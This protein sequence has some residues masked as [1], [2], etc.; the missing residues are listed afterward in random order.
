VKSPIIPTGVRISAMKFK[1]IDHSRMR[2]TPAP[3]KISIKPHIK[4]QN[5]TPV[6][7]VKTTQ[8]RYHPMITAPLAPRA[9]EPRA[10]ASPGEIICHSC[11]GKMPEDSQRCAI[12][13][14]DLKSPKVRCRRC[15]EINPRGLDKCNR[16]GSGMDE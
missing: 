13:G 7:A 2:K 10:E 1:S 4:S 12:C 11:N 6:D 5:M 9:L 3:P 14:S 16:C 15:G 8:A